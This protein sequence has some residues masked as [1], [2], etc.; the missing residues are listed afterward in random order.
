M[1]ST[2]HIHIHI[3]IHLI[4][5]LTITADKRRKFSSL[6]KRKLI[7]PH[8][9]GDAEN[10]AI[11]TVAGE[12]DKEARETITGNISAGQAGAG[13][14]GPGTLVRSVCKLSCQPTGNLNNYPGD[15]WPSEFG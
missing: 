5:R 1:N 3:D 12:R 2:I 13:Q 4:V 11:V 10:Q 6:N 14:G 9:A 15:S 8:K 7:F